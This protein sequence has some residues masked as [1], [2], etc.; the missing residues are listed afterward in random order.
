MT[1]HLTTVSVVVPPSPE[2]SPHTSRVVETAVTSKA[3]LGD[4]PESETRGWASLLSWNFN[5]L[6]VFVI[7]PITL[8]GAIFVSLKAV[9]YIVKSRMDRR[10]RH[11]NQGEDNHVSAFSSNAPL[12]NTQLT[13]DITKQH[14]GYENRSSENVRHNEN[15]I[16]EEIR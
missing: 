12:L 10:T 5:T 3:E 7:L 1:P 8:G 11:D 6:T 13:A 4:L 2:T 9:N 15:H 14:A 16:F